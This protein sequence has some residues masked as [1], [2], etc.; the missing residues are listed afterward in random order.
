MRHTIKDI[1]YYLDLVNELMP[2]NYNLKLTKYNGCYH[3]EVY[4]NNKLDFK[5]FTG[6]KNEVYYAILAI[7]HILEIKE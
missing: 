7:Y 3:I 2:S 6:T 5:L 4:K 1:E